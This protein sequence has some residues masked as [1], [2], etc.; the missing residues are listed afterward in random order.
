[1]GGPLGLSANPAGPWSSEFFFQAERVWRASPGN[2][3]K[4]PAGGAAGPPMSGEGR[5][6]PGGE[7]GAGGGRSARGGGGGAPPAGG[8]PG[9][10]PAVPAGNPASASPGRGL[11]RSSDIDDLSWRTNPPVERRQF[12]HLFQPFKR[13]HLPEGRHGP[14]PT[15][16]RMPRQPL[17]IPARLV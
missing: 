7:G 1:A 3:G 13:T 2:G 8:G 14:P 11:G 9:R 6:L 15:I 5:P 16:P 12:P 4:S 10:G 17:T